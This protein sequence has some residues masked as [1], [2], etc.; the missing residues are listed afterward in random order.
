M[1]RRPP[2]PTRRG[3]T[4]VEMLTVVSIIAVLT[5]ISVG[6]FVRVRAA[7][8]V[9][10]AE[11]TLSKLHGLMAT[12]WSAV[13]DQSRRTVP[14]PL[15]D[16]CGSD[17][18]RAQALWAYATLKNEFPMSFTEA[19]TTINLGS[20]AVLSPRS[21][22]QAIATPANVA[23]GFTPEQQSAALFYAA[24]TQGGNAGNAAGAD[25]TEQQVGTTEAG[26]KKL[27]V[28]LDTWGNPIVFIR[29]ANSPE[30]NG[31]PY[32]RGNK[33][34]LGASPQIVT[35]TLDP[36]GRLS[37]WPGAIQNTWLNLTS[38]QSGVTN[39]NYVNTQ[40]SAGYP[41]IAGLTWSPIAYSQNTVPTLVSYG[42]GGEPPFAAWTDEGNLLSYRLRREGDRG[43]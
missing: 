27:Q 36:K 35:N 26:G 13:V 4:L 2:A 16:R 30:V 15:L 21:I 7:Q 38:F 43:N 22:F 11:G 23:A 28:Y 17:P 37:A 5:A 20:G 18:D 33:T 24:I 39:Q 1:T 9:N 40:L 6:A 12:R 8:A 32:T 3:F 42:P 31:P 10:N 34:Q 25:G 41:A 19:T 29:H 14:T